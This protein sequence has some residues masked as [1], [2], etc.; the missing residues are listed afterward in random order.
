VVRRRRQKGA[1]GRHSSLVSPARTS[2]SGARLC[3]G[4]TIRLRSS[5]LRLSRGSRG[6]RGGVAPTPI[7]IAGSSVVPQTS[8]A[9]SSGLPRGFH[10]TAAHLQGIRRILLGRACETA[11]KTHHSR[12]ANPPPRLQRCSPI[13][14]PVFETNTIHSRIIVLRPHRA[15]QNSSL[16]GF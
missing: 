2:G 10:H 8:T 6:E 1:S 11:G 9:S 15:P 7:G 13:P 3:V 16:S 5:R 12:E 14:T 4:M